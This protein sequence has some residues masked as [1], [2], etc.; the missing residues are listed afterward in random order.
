MSPCNN[1]QLELS[2]SIFS[3]IVKVLAKD[4]Y[5]VKLPVLKVRTHFEL[6]RVTSRPRT[7]LVR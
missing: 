1:L 3:G 4:D 6:R 5:L 7:V 2:L